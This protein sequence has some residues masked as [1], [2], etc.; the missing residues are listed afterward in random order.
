MCGNGADASKV[1]FHD[2]TY[3]ALHYGII[4]I[5]ECP[6]HLPHQGAASSSVIRFACSAT[7]TAIVYPGYVEGAG[8]GRRGADNYLN[9]W[10]PFDTMYIWLQAS[11]VKFREHKG[12]NGVACRGGCRVVCLIL[13]SHHGKIWRWINAGNKARQIIHANYPDY[14]ESLA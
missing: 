1:K 10:R 11:R 3:E 9:N 14:S 4:T 12:W 5:A 8:V 6:G 7:S 2:C 13:H